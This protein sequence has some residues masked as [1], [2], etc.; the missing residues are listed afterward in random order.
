MTTSNLA[1]LHGKV[2][3]VTG[4]GRGL[5]R[6]EALELAKA[7][8]RVVVND[9][10]G[11]TRGDTNG[12]GR[13]H[14]ANA[15]V[16]EILAAGGEAASDLNDISTM[17]G[18]ANLVRAAREAFGRIDI[19]V[20]NAGI[21]RPCNI[22]TMSEDDWDAVIRVHLKGHFAMVRN[23]APVMI[24]QGEGGVIVNIAS[25]SGLGHWGNANYS[26]AKEGVVGFTRTVARDLGEYGI[27]VNAVRP[28]GWTRLG[29]PEMME[30]V[31][32]S[33]E[34]LG[35][36]AT[37]NLWIAPSSEIPMPEQVGVFV[38]WLCTAAA[39]SATGRTFYVGGG[40]IGLYPEPD[41]VRSI[42]QTGG[43]TLDSLDGAG[44]PQLLGD[45]ANRVTRVPAKD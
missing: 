31:R 40:T 36:P 41:P 3:I 19:L 12:E 37:G 44:G 43:W 45:L 30:T 38:A 42:Y 34:V 14:V 10:G 1:R 15:V 17:E 39:A 27:R 25:H 29:T 21:A 33:Q 13:E 8:A 9:Y 7:G 23:A 5:G 2:A 20:N 18:A 4:G 6:A 32:Y 16:E 35:I 22:A 11:S 28:L 26:A 24:E